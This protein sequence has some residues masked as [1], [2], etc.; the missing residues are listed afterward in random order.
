[1]CR[2]GAD[3]KII[4]GLCIPEHRASGKVYIGQS[5]FVY[6]YLFLLNYF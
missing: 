3:E 1:M 2:D 5:V 4:H 6:N